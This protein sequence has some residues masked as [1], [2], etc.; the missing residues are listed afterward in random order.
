MASLFQSSVNQ[1]EG[2][3]VFSSSFIPFRTVT[4]SLTT[5]IQYKIVLEY[6]QRKKV[7]KLTKSNINRQVGN[8]VASIYKRYEHML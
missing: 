1:R 7:K 4:T 6:R 3:N 8:Q 2:H 5:L